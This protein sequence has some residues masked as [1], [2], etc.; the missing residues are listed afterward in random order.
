MLVNQDRKE[1][2]KMNVCSTEGKQTR[3]EPQTRVRSSREHKTQVYW[4]R[5]E[6]SSEAG[7]H[8]GVRIIYKDSA[9]WQRQT[10][11]G[12]QLNVVACIAAQPTR[13]LQGAHILRSK[14]QC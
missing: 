12:V 1:K 14:G 4:R 6:V 11:V 13:R 10:A 5:I 9:G 7:K 8:V 3:K 2:S